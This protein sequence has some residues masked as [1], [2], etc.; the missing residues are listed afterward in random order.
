MFLVVSSVN[1]SDIYDCAFPRHV[2]V[3]WRGKTRS[4]LRSLNL[5]LKHFFNLADFLLDYAGYSFDMAF[6]C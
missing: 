4:A 2:S 5:L 6:G 1:R 3:P